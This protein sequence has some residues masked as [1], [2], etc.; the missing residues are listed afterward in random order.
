MKDII[1]T[2]D[3]NFNMLSEQSSGKIKDLRRQFSLPQIIS[4]PTHF[5]ENSSA[6]IDLLLVNDNNHVIT[7]GVGDPFFNKI[8]GTTAKYSGC[9]IFLS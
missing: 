1:I 9:L 5:T 4:Q 8:Y 3:F 2:G 6:L 7:S